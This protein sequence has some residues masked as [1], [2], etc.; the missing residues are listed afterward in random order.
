[1]RREI[2]PELERAYH[3]W[4]EGH[5]TK[6]LKEVAHS[7]AERWRSEAEHA[8]KLFRQHG[9]DTAPLHDYFSGH[10]ATIPT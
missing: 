3:Q 1:L 7:G 4:L 6:N 10:E 2:F 8:L 5:G 9:D